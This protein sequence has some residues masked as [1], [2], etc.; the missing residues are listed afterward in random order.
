MQVGWQT[1]KHNKHSCAN[2][3]QQTENSNADATV[4]ETNTA[5][6]QT[7][8]AQDSPE[9]ASATKT[10]HSCH[11]GKMQ[12]PYKTKR[13][14]SRRADDYGTWD[15]G[16]QLRSERINGHTLTYNHHKGEWR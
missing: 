13:K 11:G 7:T 5:P 8:P 15:N 4:W 12:S 1:L 9:T 6:A 14:N 2:A 10:C 16:R 3:P